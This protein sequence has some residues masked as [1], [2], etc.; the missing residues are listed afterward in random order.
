MPRSVLLKRLAE[1]PP[2]LAVPKE[3]PFLGPQALNGAV[4]IRRHPAPAPR[5]FHAPGVQSLGNLSI[6]KA[7]ARMA[8]RSAATGASA[9]NA[10]ALFAVASTFP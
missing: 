9:A 4:N 10:A 6:G 5:G 2:G 7:S 1:N 8:R 3:T